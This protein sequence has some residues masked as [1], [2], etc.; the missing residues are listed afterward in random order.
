MSEWN[1]YRLEIKCHLVIEKIQN[2]CLKTLEVST[3][4]QVADLLT[5]HLFPTQL[6]YL[7]RKMQV[8]NIHSLSW[9]DNIRIGKIYM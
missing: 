1:T 7:L 6:S 3:Q 8:H 5:K 4:H 9:G 2:D